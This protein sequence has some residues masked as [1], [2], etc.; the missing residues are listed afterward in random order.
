MS[1]KKVKIGYWDCRGLVNPIILQL[2]YLK[3]PY[4]LETP[5]KKLIGPPP[6]FDKT[7]WLEQKGELLHGFD[8]PNLPYFE[9][10]SKGLKLTQSNAILMHIARTNGLFP[11]TEDFK[12]LAQMDL[13]REEFKDVTSLITAFCYDPNVDEEKT[14][15]FY[16]ISRQKLEK[17][18]SILKQ[19]PSWFFLPG[20]NLTYIDFLAYD[21]IDHLRILFPQILRDLPNLNNFLEKFENLEPMADFMKS[22]RYRKFPLWSERSFWG[23][24]AENLPAFIS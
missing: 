20:E 10:P 3:L 1:E 14:K 18:D 2:E 4:D 16:L 5:D 23:K 21:I 13:L 12:I 22:E 24:S 17:L 6:K 19:N 11:K 15:K 7:K 8:F 9:D